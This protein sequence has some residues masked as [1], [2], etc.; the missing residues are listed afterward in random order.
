MIDGK[1]VLISQLKVNMRTNN[2]IIKIIKRK[3]QVKEVV[4]QL[5]VC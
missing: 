4:T 2:N 3:Q 5:L 1:N